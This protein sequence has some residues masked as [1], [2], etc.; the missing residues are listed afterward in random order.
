MIKGILEI[1]KNAVTWMMYWSEFFPSGPTQRDTKISLLYNL[2]FP[3]SCKLK[4]ICIHKIIYST[5]NGI[6]DFSHSLDFWLSF[7]TYIWFEISRRWPSL[8]QCQNSPSEWKSQWKCVIYV[9]KH[10]SKLTRNI[11]IF[12]ENWY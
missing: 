2:S 5:W 10:I 7:E 6:S 8:W 9:V 12:S 3:T 4:K 1:F 11:G